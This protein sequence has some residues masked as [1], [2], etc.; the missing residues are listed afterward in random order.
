M[1]LKTKVITSVFFSFVMSILSYGM[2]L[3]QFKEN[4]SILEISCG[5][6]DQTKTSLISGITFVEEK[7]RR[8]ALQLQGNKLTIIKTDETETDYYG[9]SVE[10]WDVSE[11]KN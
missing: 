8:I 10:I 5:K 3:A 6:K 9:S 11:K 7:S 1:I 2:E 4:I